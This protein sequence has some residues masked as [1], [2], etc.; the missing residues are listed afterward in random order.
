VPNENH[1]QFR[2]YRLRPVS[3]RGTTPHEERIAS[4]VPRLSEFYAVMEVNMIIPFI[5]LFFDILV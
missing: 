5:F 4:Q 1:C 3:V 2:D